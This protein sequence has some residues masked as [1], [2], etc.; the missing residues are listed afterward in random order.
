MVFILISQRFPSL[1]K[2]K[3]S[4]LVNRSVLLHL[5]A[6]SVISRSHSS[7][8][9]TAIPGF[10]SSKR[11]M[12]WEFD[13]PWCGT[14]YKLIFF[15]WI[16]RN[17]SLRILNASPVN[18]IYICL[19]CIHSKSASSA[20]CLHFTKSQAVPRY[21]SEYLARLLD[22]LPQAPEPHSAR[23]HY[24]NNINNIIFMITVFLFPFSAAYSYKHSNTFRQFR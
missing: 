21:I 8:V 3:P 7:E 9:T 22:A 16:L 5:F 20:K 6:A 1:T 4:G 23:S 10:T 15:Q 19:Y 14:L 2:L 18:S 13:L 12:L 24:E 11:G 17:S